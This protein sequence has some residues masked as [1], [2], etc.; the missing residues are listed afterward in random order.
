[1]AGSLGDAVDASTIRL[2]TGLEGSWDV[3]SAEG[4]AVVPTFSAALHYDAGDAETGLGVEP[5]Y[6]LT[7]TSPGS[8]ISLSAA[9]RGL[10]SRQKEGGSI[11]FQE[12]GVSGSIRYDRGDN[13]LVL[14]ITISPAWGA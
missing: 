11:A 8:G 13:D 7:Y 10:L 5:G 9:I 6:G 2:R 1:M 3:Q 12:W 14:T 4:T